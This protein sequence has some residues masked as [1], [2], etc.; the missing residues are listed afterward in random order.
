M[1]S[2][3]EPLT[4]RVEKR[5]EIQVSGRSDWV[6]SEDISQDKKWI[7]KKRFCCTNDWFHCDIL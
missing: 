6:H 4:K 3:S 2:E 5:K 1:I 7:E